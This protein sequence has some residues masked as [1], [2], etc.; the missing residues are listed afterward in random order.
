[1]K[2]TFYDN[3]YLTNEWKYDKSI[4]LNRLQSNVFPFIF[5]NPEII[6]EIGCGL[7]FHTNLWHSLGYN[8]VGYDSSNVAIIKAK[9]SF[10]D[11]KYD[12]LD[13]SKLSY[14]HPIGSI[15]I[16][17]CRGLR[18]YHYELNNKNRFDID[19]FK[20]TEKLF[21]LLKASGFFILEIITDHSGTRPADKVHNN[22]M[23]DYLTLFNRFGACISAKDWNGNELELTNNDANINKTGVTL[24]IKKS[25]IL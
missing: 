5:K 17:Y 19:V 8:I 22:R 24:V 16:I 21:S 9:E 1:M 6:V 25:D 15:D 12:N 14:F 2:K 20:E 3:Y 7:G 23:N 13:V 18:W 10:P 11:A 4:E